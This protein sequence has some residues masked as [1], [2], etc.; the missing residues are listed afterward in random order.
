MSSYFRYVVEIT[1]TQRGPYYLMPGKGWPVWTD[2]IFSA[3]MTWFKWRA[4]RWRKRAGEGFVAQHGF[5][6]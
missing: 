3:R 2:D 6:R 4:E 5:C 1:V